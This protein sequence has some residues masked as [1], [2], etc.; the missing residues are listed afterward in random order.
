MSISA[1]KRRIKESVTKFMYKKPK[2][3]EPE[4]HLVEEPAEEEPQVE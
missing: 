3:E 1:I 2:V 4:E